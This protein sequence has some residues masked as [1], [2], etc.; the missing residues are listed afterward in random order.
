MR[1]AIFLR[2]YAADLKWVPYALRSIHKFVSGV[3]EIIICVPREDMALFQS[4]NLTRELLVPSQPSTEDGYLDQQ[5]SKLMADFYTG[6]S[7]ILYWD[8]DVLATRPFSPADLMLE[9]TP[10]CLMTPYAKLVN[11]DGS[12]AT[13]WQPIVEKALGNPKDL[14][15]VTYE[16]MRSHPFFAP[17]TALEGLRSY[18]EAIHDCSIAKYI[19]RQPHRAFS[20]FNV[21]MAWAHWQR[22]ELFYWWD[23]E[24]MGVPEP[25]AK[26]FWSYSGLKDEERA[27]MEKILK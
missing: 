17:R 15:R 7:H 27:E 5:A 9:G 21:L 20:E 19:T 11:A 4:L 12:Q 6:A 24:V 10:R 1:T 25:F 2:S 23:T 14:Y 26:Q 16:Y 13:P 3:D 8:S 18:M 22:P